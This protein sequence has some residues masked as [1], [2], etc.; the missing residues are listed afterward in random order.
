MNEPELDF[1]EIIL[2]LKEKG[3]L[4]YLLFADLETYE[5]FR[6][7]GIFY[8]PHPANP[9]KIE[10]YKINRDGLGGT[11][12]NIFCY[13]PWGNKNKNQL[14]QL[15]ATKLFQKN[16]KDC[17]LFTNGMGSWTKWADR[18]QITYYDQ[19]YLPVDQ[20]YKNI[21]NYRCGLHVTLSESFAYSVLDAFLLEV[22]VVCSPAINW[23]PMSLIVGTPDDPIEIA[24]KLAEIYDGRFQSYGK[25]AR[26]SAIAKITDNNE[27][28]KA[29]LDKII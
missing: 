5:V 29:I 19:G 28:V 14:T 24:E 23:A 26:N 20:Y 7:D 22:P 21:Q 27:K 4:D 10:Q 15:A 1:L 25:A 16:Y 11:I 12:Q 13:M 18:L 8:L 6:E 3:A 17:W 2:S 9:K